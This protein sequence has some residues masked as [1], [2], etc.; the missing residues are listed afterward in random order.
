MDALQD[1]GSKP[2]RPYDKSLEDNLKMYDNMPYNRDAN[3]CNYE[4]IALVS[5]N[6]IKGYRCNM[7]DP[8][9]LKSSQTTST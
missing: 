3:L 9:I 7:R 6:L 2:L 4:A 1:K 8:Y 5:G